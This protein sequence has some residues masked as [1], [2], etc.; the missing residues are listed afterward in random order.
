MVLSRAAQAEAP[1]ALPQDD[2]IE[3]PEWDYDEE[4]ADTSDSA[5]FFGSEDDSE[6]G[7]QV[8]TAYEL[9]KELG[10]L[11]GIWEEPRTR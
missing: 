8:M 1:V 4:E 11:K 6:D 2:A 3:E 7:E 5:E 9:G 10:R